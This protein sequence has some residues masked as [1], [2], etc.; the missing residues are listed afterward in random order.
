MTIEKLV[1]IFLSF[2]HF[3]T[4]FVRLFSSPVWYC[5]IYPF[6]FLYPLF[7]HPIRDSCPRN[8]I[9]VHRAPSSSLSLDNADAAATAAT[10]NRPSRVIG[11]FDMLFLCWRSRNLSVNSDYRSRIDDDDDIKA[12]TH[13]ADCSAK[14][15]L[16]RGLITDAKSN[17][18][19]RHDIMRNY[20]HARSPRFITCFAVFANINIIVIAFSS[21]QPETTFVV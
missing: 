11:F 14:E 16:D 17:A 6:F 2:S 19:L 20:S 18:L 7:Y 5:I 9:R 3:T 12:T 15:N 4:T 8:C 13:P 21:W 10:G 1:L